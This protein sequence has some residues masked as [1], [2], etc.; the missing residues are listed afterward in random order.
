MHEFKYSKE[1]LSKIVGRSLSH[2][3]NTLRLLNLPE[4]VREMVE[5]KQ[6]S[7]GHARA[8]ITIPEQALPLAQ[9]IMEQG[10]NV[11]QVEELVKEHKDKPVIAKTAP[12]KVKSHWAEQLKPLEENF[13]RLTG[14]PTIIRPVGSGGKITLTFSGKHDLEMLLLRFQDR[15]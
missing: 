2:V 5:N 10:L 4:E 6:L 14:L 8:L 3:T 11:R 15:K 13:A 12:R 9:R 7:A 1:G